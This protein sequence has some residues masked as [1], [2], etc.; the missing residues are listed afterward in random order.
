MTEFAEQYNILYR[1]QFGFRIVTDVCYAPY[2]S[3]IHC[4]YCT[5]F[6]VINKKKN[7]NKEKCLHFVKTIQRPML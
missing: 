4:N 7:I 5:Y 1:C 3:C 6:V 2:C